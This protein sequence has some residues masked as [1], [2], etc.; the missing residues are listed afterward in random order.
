M[1]EDNSLQRKMF[2]ELKDAELFR[3]A[4]SFGMDYL[5]SIFDRNVY[6]S[7]SALNDLSIFEEDFPENSGDPLETLNL[8]NRYGAPG[9]TAQ[10]GG[11]YFGFVHG[12]II[13]VGLAAKNLA[14]FWDQ[15]ATVYQSSPISSKLE[16]VVQK[17][18]VQLLS[19]PSET[20]AGFVSGT[21]T[22]NY[23]ALAAARYRIL[24]NL[25]W[26]VTTKGLFNAPKIRVVAGRQVHSSMLQAISLAGFGIDNIELVEVDDQ[27]RIL[28]DKIPKLD[29]TTILS[30][31]AGNVNTGSFDD[32]ASICKKAKEQ[33]AWIHVDGAFGLWAGATQHFKHLTVG[34]EYANSWAVDAHKT[35]NSPYDSGIIFCTDEEALISSLHINAAYLPNE[36][37]RNGMYYVPEMSRRSRVIELW[38]ILRYLGRTGIEELIHNLHKRALQ[39]AE[40][41]NSE[42]GFHVLNQ[43]VYNQVLVQCDNDTLTEKV[44]KEIQEMR[45][46]WVGGS[47]W[48]GRKVIRISVCSWATTEENVNRSVDSFSKALRNIKN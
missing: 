18:L 22:A 10:I 11:R 3:R 24:K 35:L 17:W 29:N 34:Y 21:S 8:L 13:P 20:I 46:C 5:R 26:D 36:N 31:Q 4:E 38:A 33:G 43:V 2:L 37:E 1:K 47:I 42:K 9:T 27:G 48:K 32:F 15:N 30:L 12:G 14:T 7:K 16:T 25:N 45:E 19:L 6:P 41:L 23:C 44:L 40:L 39:F 28:A